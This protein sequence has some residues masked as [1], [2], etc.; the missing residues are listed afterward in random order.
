MHKLDYKLSVS[1]FEL[2]LSNPS[3]AMQTIVLTT[4]L[5]CECVKKYPGFRPGQDPDGQ[6]GPFRSRFKRVRI[7][8]VHVK[9]MRIA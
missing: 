5:A 1:G 3:S 8:G 2:K 9:G 4:I 6:L 7:G